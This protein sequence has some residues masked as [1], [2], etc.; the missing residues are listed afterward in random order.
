M[1]IL[2]NEVQA[3]VS[4]AT[5]GKKPRQS[6][7]V[8]DT[9]QPLFTLFPEPAAT[10][11][12]GGEPVASARPPAGIGSSVE[13]LAAD[14]A[15]EPEPP[16]ATTTAAEA[17]PAGDNTTTEVG[18]PPASAAEESILDKAGAARQV[19]EHGAPVAVFFRD[20]RLMDAQ[21]LSK[22]LSDR[23]LNYGLIPDDLSS[24]KVQLPVGSYRIVRVNRMSDEDEKRFKAVREI[25]ERRA[26]SQHVTITNVREDQI[27]N[28]PFQVQLY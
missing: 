19:Q 9:V 8:W 12:A 26:G 28:K 5:K 13:R 17:P 24:V 20:D 23:G 18:A 2:A 10:P 6:P 22:E 27:I 3:N 11:V 15:V 21:A 14:I 1:A 25:L 16:L 4:L 7:T